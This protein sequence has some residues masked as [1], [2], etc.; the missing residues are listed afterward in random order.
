MREIIVANGF[1]GVTQLFENRTSSYFLLGTLCCLPQRRPPKIPHST[2][3]PPQRAQ[4]LFDVPAL[5]CIITVWFNMFIDEHFADIF[6]VYC[7]LVYTSSKTLCDTKPPSAGT[8]LLPRP[9]V[10]ALAQG[11]PST[12]IFTRLPLQVRGRGTQNLLIQ[13]QTCSAEGPAL[14]VKQM[15][16]HSYLV[17]DT[18]T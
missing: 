17:S 8:Q 7:S 9:G 4:L 3:S 12:A 5:L 13:L 11:W 2:S 15:I 14:I 1:C 10:C 6:W 18:H 16:L